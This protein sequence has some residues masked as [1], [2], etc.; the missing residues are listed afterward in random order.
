MSKIKVIQQGLGEIGKGILRGFI[1]RGYEIVGAVDIR[2]DLAGK[3]LK[4]IGIEGPAEN[5]RIE[6][7]WREIAKKERVD[8]LSNSTLSSF[9]D[10]LPELEEMSKS[11]W[12]RAIISTCE[13]LSFPYLRFYNQACALD[14]LL[15]LNGVSLLATGVNPGFVMDT[16]P[17]VATSTCLSV[18][19]IEVKRVMNASKRREAFQRKIGAGT[20]IEEFRELVKQGKIRHVGLSESTAMIAVGL[21]FDIRDNELK[22]EESIPEPIIAYK[23]FKTQ[24]V[25]VKKG[26]PSGV[27]Q[28]SYCSY[29]KEKIITL[30]FRAA[31]DIEESYDSVEV[32]EKGKKESSVYIKAIGGF[33]GDS[34]TIA[35]VLNCAPFLL[36]ASPGLKTMLDVPPRF[37]MIT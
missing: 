16:L 10:L 3:R 26:N 7:D 20:T 21:G 28:S 15:K 36:S 11:G 12:I 19:K 31:V 34:A 8:I 1:E 37:R 29:K 22:I 9:L 5:L 13:E 18:E 17:L 27:Y 30:E 35:M 4:D 32:Y 2:K 33:F 24:F 6:K 25:E 23:D 14:E